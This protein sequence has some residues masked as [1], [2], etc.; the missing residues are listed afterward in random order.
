MEDSRNRNKNHKGF[1]IFALLLLIGIIFFMNKD[2]QVDFIEAYKSLTIRD[3]TLEKVQSIELDKN[4]ERVGLFNKNIAIWSGSKLSIIDIDSNLLLEKQ[5]NFETPDVIFGDNDSYIMDK[6]TGDVY[7]INNKGETI[8]RVVL[9]KRINN[10][11]EDENN[12]I[13]HTKSDEEENLVIL[14]NMGAFLRVHPIEDMDI[15]TYNLDKYGD[16]YLISNLMIEDK[17]KSEVYIY[18]I[19][20]ELLNT[21]KID[22]E[23]IIFTEFVN[24]DLIALTDKCLYY[25]RDEEIYWRKSLSNIKDIIL[26][27]EEIY[28][29]Y[30]QNLEIIDLEGRTIEKLIFTEHLNRISAYDKLL[31]L[32]GNYDLLGIQSNKEILKYKQNELIKDI[33]INKDYLGLVD[34]SGIHLFE[35]K[36]K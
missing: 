34:N 10:L 23:I 16:K 7:I 31:L 29:L 30:G 20:G 28:I 2:N 25:I 15:L 13:V 5:F 22:N 33:I 8:E 12:L 3:K 1:K 6:S 9:D 24:D 14:S 21:N 18:S 36:N 26:K 19:D 11:I 35:I 27:D 4:V 32:W 17:L